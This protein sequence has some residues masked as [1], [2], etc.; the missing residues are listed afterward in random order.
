MRSFTLAPANRGSGWL[1]ILLPVI[2][3]AFAVW[4]VFQ[5]LS[6]I[7]AQTEEERL[8]GVERAVIR[9]AVKCYAVEGQYPAS[10][11]YLEE[12]YGLMVDYDKYIVHI[13][14]SGIGNVMPN[15][16]IQPRN[17]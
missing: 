7:D 3:V 8:R 14:S 9:A 10:Y 13:D 1:Q 11:R 4:V 6:G 17:F 16:I 15:I 5:G 12:N 2:T